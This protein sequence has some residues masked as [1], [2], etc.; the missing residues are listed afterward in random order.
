MHRL[1]MKQNSQKTAFL[2]KVEFLY[3]IS[4]RVYTLS[5]NFV[6]FRFRPYRRYLTIAIRRSHRRYSTLLSQLFDTLI[7][8]TRRY[9]RRYPTVRFRSRRRYLTAITVIIRRSHRSY[10]TLSPSLSDAIIV[11]IRRYHRRYSTLL[12]SLLGA[13]TIITRLLDFDLTIVIS[14]QL[15]D[16]H[17]H[18]SY[19]TLI[20]TAATR[21]SHRRYSIFGYRGVFLLHSAIRVRVS[22]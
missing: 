9:Y 22:K 2:Q 19:P 8:A 20:F 11:A 15:L 16:V 18:R 13:I 12:S 21:R 17:F 1:Y 14:R 5:N 10:P 7:V 6:V 3:Y 4:G